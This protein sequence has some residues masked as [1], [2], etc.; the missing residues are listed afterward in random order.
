M[1]IMIPNLHPQETRS[2]AEVDIYYLLKEGLSDEFTVIHS[3][4]WLCGDVRLSDKKF[5]PTGE[6]DFLVI[7]PEI[8]VLALEVKGGFYQVK[9]VQFVRVNGNETKNPIGQMR[10][11]SHGLARR[12]GN[13]PSLRVR[14]GY[15]FI[16]PDSRFADQTPSIALTDRSGP[17]SQRIFIDCTEMQNL[18]DRVREMMEYWNSINGTYAL[19]E[20]KTKHLIS[21]ICPEYDGTPSWGWRILRDN[22]TWLRLTTEQEEI[23][24]LASK[25]QRMLI[26]GWP[27]T[28]KTVIGIELAIRAANKG[29]K[30]LI[31]V[32]NS[33]LRGA[34]QT[35]TAELGKNCDVYTWHGL[36]AEARR[37]LSS[38]FNSSDEWRDVLCLN[39]LLAANGAGL[40]DEYDQLVLDEAQALRYAWV[41]ALTSWFAEKNVYAFCDETQIFSFERE[42]TNLA[43]LSELIKAKPFPLSVVLRT[44]NAVFERLKLMRSD[45]GCQ[46]TSPRPPDQDTLREEFKIDWAQT[47]EACIGDLLAQNIEPSGITVLTRYRLSETSNTLVEIISR[48]GIEHEIVSR[49]RGLESAAIVILNAELMDDAELFCAYS[50]ATSVCVAIY[51]PDRLADATGSF[52]SFLKQ[53]E[54]VNALIEEIRHTTLTSNLVAHHSQ[55]ISGVHTAQLAWSP[56]F[57]GWLIE[58]QNDHDPSETWIDYL[59]LYF[60][61]PVYHWYTGARRVIYSNSVIES[62]ED[63]STTKRYVLYEC[64]LCHEITPHTDNLVRKC[65]L[66]NE[67]EYVADE[68]PS[69][70][71][72]AIFQTHD[73]TIRGTI[74]KLIQPKEIRTL[75]IPLAAV[76]A[77]MYGAAN[78]RRNSACI[79][80]LPSSQ[81]L[82][83]R[84]AMAFVLARI[85]FTNNELNRKLLSD[86]IF[87]SYDTW[88]DEVSREKWN[89]RMTHVFATC[90][91]HKKLMSK[92]RKGV[93]KPIDDADG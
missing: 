39:D 83:Y 41:S 15:G 21:S 61:W 34:I 56:A 65:V 38:P 88:G 75:P 86:R 23:L 93:F 28:G 45:I 64:D 40:M 47:L 36:C 5:T 43:Q 16:F 62:M 32:F 87:D 7:H 77:R 76:A 79:E 72:L 63:W 10:N 6:I 2:R 58:L 67:M 20:E 24:N 11:N 30:T 44:P 69:T 4:P 92:V 9:G 3:L 85:T 19:G 89:E 17:E 12:L 46:L 57:G 29:R 52:H 54:S 90:Y 68:V 27:G 35:R 59:V 91:N 22:Q 18:G 13:D 14:I 70:E 25:R 31:V 55:S 60:T 26:T 73:A 78:K 51:D 50:R 80:S 81:C 37:R 84:V 66:C 71:I 8:G 48:F 53:G 82:L 49:F 42:T 1:A 74:E 33:L